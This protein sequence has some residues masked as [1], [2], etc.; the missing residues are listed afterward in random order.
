MKYGL[1]EKQLDQIIAI[2]KSYPDVEAAIL[3]GSRAINTFKE[4]S[5]VDIVI[6][7]EK[8]NFALAARIK[9]HLEDETYLP[10]FF[11]I[12][13]YNSIDNDALKL[14]IEKYGKVLYEKNEVRDEWKQC[15]LGDVL[16]LHYGKALPS[17]KRIAG[18]IPVYSSAGLT[19]YHNETLVDSEGL[20]IGRKGSIGKIYKSKG[21]FFAIDTS[22]YILPSSTY[23]LQFVYYLL[24]TLG[25]EELNEDS[26]V[27]GLNR[28]T[29][30]SQEILLPPL[31]EQKT[32]AE[33][34]SSLDD[35]IDL[36]HRQNKTLES[37]A[38]T[39]FRQWFIEEASEE[40]EEKSLLEFIEVI[41][42]GTPKTTIDEYWNGDVPWLSG[43]DIAANHKSFIMYSEKSITSQGLEHSSAKLL[44]KLATVISARGTVGKFGLLSK[45]MA[46]SQSNYG[47]LP[48]I[49]NC[50][51][52]TY[53]LINHVVNELQSSAYGSV[54]DT[55]TT[56]T[57][58]DVSINL[59]N[60]DIIKDFEEKIAD[61]FHKK[62]SC[63]EQIYKLEKIRDTLLPK[64]MNAEIR[65]QYK[66]V[67]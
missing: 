40:W 6:K 31:L 7:G 47:I 13:A 48:K 8:A 36:L 44:P 3:F 11:D 20:I 35:K 57:F 55:I 9:G 17:H 32:I 2:I 4:A 61:S 41:G 59:P 49:K 60:E 22:Y 65:V 18:E 66:G 54:F 64:F 25:L 56:G 58:S 42:G 39:L 16:T 29:A 67:D 53:L 28:E 10:F 37:L 43:G 51:F 5:D 24:Q 45:P 1:S 30:Y 15:Q 38:E 19:G 27:P 23:E 12:I 62:L 26:A 50:F 33:V 14:H 52:F 63:L 34:L 21:P 46:Y